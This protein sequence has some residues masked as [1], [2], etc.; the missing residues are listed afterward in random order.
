MLQRVMSRFSI[1]C[2]KFF[3]SQ[4]QK[5]LHVNPFVLFFRKYRVAKKLMYQ[6]GGGEYQDFPSEI[7][8][9][10]VPKNFVGES[11]T[12]PAFLGTGKVWIRKGEYQD[13]P[14]IVFC[15]TVPKNFLGESFSVSLVSGIENFMRQ[16]VMSRF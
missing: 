16:R 9:L 12:V 4:C 7:F 11:I 2:R 6:R 5:A 13:F 8:Y 1:F 15:F 3:V 10:T 14:S